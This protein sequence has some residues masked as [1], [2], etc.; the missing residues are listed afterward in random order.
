MRI[1]IS[2]KKKVG[3]IVSEFQDS[4]PYLTLNFYGARDGLLTG[5]TKQAIY[6]SDTALSEI[7]PELAEGYI[8]V[9]ETMSVK[10]LEQRLRDLF[11]LNVQVLRRSG[12]VWLETT[13]TD[14]W[15]LFHQNSHGRE[16][17]QKLRSAASDSNES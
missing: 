11:R 9:P 7:Q 3:D 4:Y 8:D 6:P 17:T 12:N 16:L 10:Q 13:A 1:E 14:N 2:G 15:S 5:H